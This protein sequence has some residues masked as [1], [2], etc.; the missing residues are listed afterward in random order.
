MRRQQETLPKNL[1]GCGVRGGGYNI[2]PLRMC[3]NGIIIIIIILTAHSGV[4]RGDYY[5][6]HYWMIDSEYVELRA[7]SSRL[8][9][10]PSAN[11]NKYY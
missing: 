11:K 5:S 10:Q 2:H 3:H 8:R 9:T 1:S 7:Q 4:V 6:S